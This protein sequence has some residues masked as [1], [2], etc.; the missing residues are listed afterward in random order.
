[1]DKTLAFLC[2]SHDD[3]G[4]EILLDPK[5]DGVYI[6]WDEVGRQKNVAQVNEKLEKVSGQLGG[7]FVINPMWSKKMGR[8][9]VTAHPL[10]GCPMGENGKAAVVNHKGQVFDGTFALLIF[11]I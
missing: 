9:L 2:M 11:G 7:T 5:S 10:G 6:K 1:M 4:G 3:A 8:E